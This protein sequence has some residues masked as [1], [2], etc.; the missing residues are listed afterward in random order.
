M[1]VS[2]IVSH[3][4]AT[5]TVTTGLQESCCKVQNNPLELVHFVVPQVQLLVFAVRP[6][7]IIQS[8]SLAHIL[9]PCLLMP[10]S[11]FDE[12]WLLGAFVR[13]T[14]RWKLFNEIV[15]KSAKLPG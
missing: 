6:S 5:V 15:P 10:L 1:L 7:V 13:L 2:W 14:P 12:L 8:S 3:H 11:D 9:K 4:T